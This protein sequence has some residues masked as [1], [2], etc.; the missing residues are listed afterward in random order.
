MPVPANLR[1]EFATLEKSFLSFMGFFGGQG[2]VLTN[3]DRTLQA[4]GGGQGLLL[5]DRVLE[6][7]HAH[8]VFQQRALEL[9]SR[10]WRVEAASEDAAD[11]KAAELVDAQL[12]ALGVRDYPL[13]KEYGVQGFDGVA[14]NFLEAT[15]KGYGVGEVMWAADGREIFAAELRHKEQQRFGWVLGDGGWELRLITDATG[16]RGEAIPPRKIVYHSPTARDSNPYGL[17]LCSKVFWPVFFKRQNIQFWLIFADKFGSPTP[18]GKYPP[19][20]SDPDKQT[21]LEALA[22]LTQGLATTV[23]EGMLIEFLEAT[24]SGNVTTYEGLARFMDEQT[25]ECVLGQTGTTNQSDGGGS[26]A[27]DEVARTGMMALIRADADLLSRTLDRTLI[28]WIVDANRP[29][30]GE[31]ARPPHFRWVF[32]EGEDLTAIATRD[33]LLF[34]M[35]FRRTPESVAEVYGD[36]YELGQGSGASDEL[37]DSANPEQ[38]SEPLLEATADVQATALNGAQISSLMELVQAVANGQ[39]PIESAVQLIQISFPMV[40][41]ARAKALL[42]PTQGFEPV[43][44]S[45]A[46]PLEPSPPSPLSQG[47]EGELE[48]EG[49]EVEMAEPTFAAPP[50]ATTTAD[51]FTQRLGQEASPAMAGMLEALRQKLAEA[52]SLEAFKISLNT[53]YPDLDDGDL[54]QLLAEA[55]GAARLAGMYEAQEGL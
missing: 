50:F 27:R 53:A 26:R 13:A 35:G 1:Q 16:T 19:G 47:V 51:L 38:A 36:G 44:L 55:M 43:N 25:S 18:V 33:K 42:T 5:Y 21:L 6:D 41:E 32:E 54:V 48:P 10:D 34:D 14:L 39:L 37:Q 11:V 31:G 9:V 12:E 22:N 30:L 52:D 4:R 40:D 3:P 23:P 28:R 20:T 24:R 15:P 17:G 49:D 46:L 29:L 7:C 2:F 45:D 8:A